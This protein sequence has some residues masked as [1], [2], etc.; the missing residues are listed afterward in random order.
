MAWITHSVEG[1]RTV[2]DLALG[3]GTTLSKG[4]FYFDQGRVQ[5][6]LSLKP[7]A[8]PSGGLVRQFASV[9]A[10][11][12]YQYLFVGSTGSDLIVY[13]HDIAVYRALIPVCSNGVRSI[14]KLSN[15]DLLCGGGDGTLTK[16]R[17]ED[18]MWE[19]IQRVRDPSPPVSCLS[20]LPLDPA[21]RLHL[22]ALLV[23]F[24][25]RGSRR[26]LHWIYLPV[27]DPVPH[28]SARGGCSHLAHLL[29][30]I[31]VL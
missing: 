3:V 26:L 20:S 21:Q 17:G 24:P 5:W 23:L 2:Y 15:G 16:I 13:R 19:V 27:H 31:R 29:H 8:L 7:Y 4:K 12:D 1:R 14:S 28:P 11:D 18:L 25:S 10:S 6:T 30:Q 9:V 22:L